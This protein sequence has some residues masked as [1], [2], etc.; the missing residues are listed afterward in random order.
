MPPSRIKFT[1]RPKSRQRGL[2][3]R[4][5]SDGDCTQHASRL[6]S[7]SG[8]T[9]VE[10]APSS[11]PPPRRSI[12]GR[13]WFLVPLAVVGL[14]VVT[15]VAL[16]LV[17]TPD[18]VRV[19]VVRALTDDLGVET[20]IGALKYHPLFGL[21]LADVKVK[22]PVGYTRSP[23]EVGRL[24]VAYDLSRLV[25]GEAAVRTVT[26][27]NAHVVFETRNGKSNLDALLD[28]VAAKLGPSEP[29]P[30]EP[31]APPSSL[32]PIAVRL[33][34]LSLGPLTFEVAGDGPHARL[35]DVWLRGEGHLGTRALTASVALTIEPSP[36][37]R[38]LTFSLPSSNQ[39]TTGQLTATARLPVSL[40]ADTA[41][42]F[43]LGRS[44]VAL[45][46]R[47]D[48]V[49][50]RSSAAGAAVLPVSG[51]TT[52]LVATVAPDDGRADVR[53]LEVTLDQSTLLDARASARGAWTTLQQALG[54]VAAE[55]LARSLGLAPSDTPD[56]IEAEVRTLHLPLTALEPLAQA[57]LP[58]LNRVQGD[59]RAKELMVAGGLNDL[60]DGRPFAL[61]GTVETERVQVD[62]PGVIVL[63]ALDGDLTAGR[64]ADG[65]YQARGRFALDQLG[66]AG[67]RI[68]HGVLTVAAGVDRLDVATG[69][70]TA[71]VTLDTTDL[72]TPPLS[73]ATAV[74]QVFL[75]GEDPLQPRRMT[76]APVALSA[77][78]QGTNVRIRGGA[79]LRMKRVDA[80]A[81]VRADRIVDA[82]RRP[83]ILSLEA[84]VE[85]FRQP[86]FQARAGRVSISGSID[87]VRRRGYSSELSVTGWF[88]RPSSS[89]FRAQRL[90]LTGRLGVDDVRRRSLGGGAKAILPA[91]ARL[92][93]DARARQAHF[94]G[95][96]APLRLYVN[97]GV[98]FADDVIRVRSAWL[99]MG[100]DTR[101]DVS[102]RLRRV[103]RGRPSGRV[104][105]VL[106]VDDAAQLWA[107]IPAAMRGPAGDV[108]ADGALQASVD[109]R[110]RWPSP[111]PRRIDWQKPPARGVVHLHTQNL[112]VASEAMA[113]D[114]RGMTATVSAQ[115]AP[116]IAALTPKVRV[117]AVQLTSGATVR[118]ATL[119]GR[120]GLEDGIWRAAVNARADEV[121]TVL[122]GD[123]YADRA[124]I[125]LSAQYVPRGELSLERLA[126]HLPSAGLVVNGTGRLRRDP[127]GDFV[128]DLDVDAQVDL[129]RFVRLVPAF[130]AG[131]GGVGAVVRVRPGPNQTLGIDGRLQLERFGWSAAPSWSVTDATGTVPV[132]QTFF[133][134]SPPAGA[135]GDV[136]AATDGLAGDDV[137][138]RMA[139][140]LRRLA[141]IRL[142]VDPQTDILAVAP[143]TADHYALSPYRNAADVELVA[144]ELRVR[145]TPLYNLRAEARLQEG[146]LRIDRFQGGLWEGDLLFDVAVQVTPKLDLKTRLRGTLTDLNLDIPYAAAKG[147]TPVNDPDEKAEYLAS[148]IMDVEFGL[149]Q[150]A[151][152]GQ[153][154]VVRL[155]RALVDRFF[156]ALDPSG[157]SSAAEAL[158]FSEFAA[159]RPVAAKLWIAQNLLNVQFEWERVLGFDDF[160]PWWLVVDTALFAPRI[161][162]AWVLGGAWVIP[163]VNNSV[164]RAS[165]A[166]FIDPYLGPTLNQTSALLAGFQSRVVSATDVAELAKAPVQ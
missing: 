5:K 13:W 78:V 64:D 117:H 72:S 60:L 134:P 54:S 126:A 8:M 119:D 165:V 52:R 150:R 125:D 155:S 122:D 133:L 22:P 116:G 59:V 49:V 71:T 12:V 82:A 11:P 89:G 92:R 115:V 23:L 16:P 65:A 112:S 68:G 44:K 27:E 20:E 41:A 47:V 164:K 29:E 148:G 77:K 79:A 91:E 55:G 135:G 15:I 120:I 19:Q 86:A 32:T 61:T 149:N 6:R 158:R 38:N 153:M 43:R 62:W 3:R 93:L 39:T 84:E 26:L 127:R 57:L 28:A 114:V 87:D 105:T 136:S 24:A 129:D 99:R 10:A 34:A 131:R 76:P 147:I 104:R 118:S 139:R 17:L 14:V 102:G 152:E 100:R 25:T 35:D 107:R 7:T 70:T 144:S 98:D 85:R 48:G 33:D 96:D 128:P 138:V 162:S 83:W 159:V 151:I 58:R 37:S 40:S 21:E 157:Q 90:T 132:A 145:D 137:E 50:E 113:L 140:L 130:Q 66:V 81:T 69:A 74:A 45:A 67:Q 160:A 156:G 18:F 124:S 163:T 108:V 143:R 154:D 95:I 53:A 103:F 63:D 46:A 94:Q 110:G 121:E 97:G 109:L 36:A 166:N 123:R 9:E 30:D 73:A 88:S 1:P 161:V 106:R 80:Q 111:W 4:T 56:R 51:L 75:R 2:V 101:L 31:D 42:G 142:V 146:V 141:D